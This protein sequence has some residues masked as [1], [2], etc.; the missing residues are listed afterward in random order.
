MQPREPHCFSYPDL[1]VRVE[2]SHFSTSDGPSE[3]HVLVEP[4]ADGSLADQLEVLA[5]AYERALAELAI[6]GDSAVWRR[7]FL[8]DP[9]NQ[10]ASLEAHPL[11]SE[12]ADCAV[13]LIGQAPQSGSKLALLAYH[14]VD[15]V[16]LEATR[17]HKRYEL[18]R[19]ALRHQWCT[20]FSAPELVDAHTQSLSI[21]DQYMDA[22][23]SMEANL[24]E[25]AI[26]T[27]IYVRDVDHNYAEMVNARNE[28]FAHEG[29]TKESHYIAST[30][31]ESR[32]GK[33]NALVFMDAYSIAGLLPEQVDYLQ[34]EEHLGRTDDYGVCFERATAVSYR[35]RKHIFIS[36][37][38]SIDPNG[39]VLFEGDV[40]RQL[41]RAIENVEALLAAANAKLEDMAHWIVYLR[42]PADAVRVRAAIEERIV[43][44]PVMIVAGAVCRPTWLVEIEGLAIAPHTDES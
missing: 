30:G 2:V 36:G 12:E 20:K 24:L 18:Q 10:Y 5:R 43:N 23:G 25:N 21:F 17:S 44:V 7:C 6:S 11:M 34:A 9:A 31:I 27:W 35:D 39:E 26:R 33:V 16:E 40:I 38:A 29:L 19:G 32:F 14:I 37:T 41:Q 22:L 1:S 42:D 28:V 3:Y 13:S 8:S 4:D 15:A